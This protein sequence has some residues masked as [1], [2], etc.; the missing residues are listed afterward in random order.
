MKMK[1][2]VSFQFEAVHSWPDCPIEGVSF[3]KHP[4]RHMFHVK[5]V[6]PVTHSDRDVEI[7]MLKRQMQEMV[8][9]WGADLGSSSCE[10]IA[11]KLIRDFLLD[12]CEVL[13]DG[14]NGAIVERV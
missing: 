13:E 4:H 11:E 9:T 12:S 8:K 1:V 5:A 2:V 7:I 10:M 6:K 3:L 14:E